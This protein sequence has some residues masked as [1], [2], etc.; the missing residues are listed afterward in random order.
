MLKAPMV[1]KQGTIH[2]NN[3]YV[4]KQHVSDG[5]LSPCSLYIL[6]H[7]IKIP[8]AASPVGW[9]AL[10]PL[11]WTSIIAG[12]CF[13]CAKVS[14]PENKFKKENIPKL[15]PQFRWCCSSCMHPA[16][17]FLLDKAS[18]QSVV[19]LHKCCREHEGHNQSR[20]PWLWKRKEGIAS[21]GVCAKLNDCMT[22]A[23]DRDQ[24]TTLTC[25]ILSITDLYLLD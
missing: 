25:Q 12:F 3:V 23:L 15:F 5:I 24:I 22:M 4:Y 20:Q 6:I 19:W 13:L 21:A 7:D 17:S 11:P 9:P 2:I 10:F 16:T 8:I 1:T 18:I 14:I